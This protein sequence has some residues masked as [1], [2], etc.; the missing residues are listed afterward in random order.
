L[1]LLLWLPISLPIF[2]PL[3]WNNL[4]DFIY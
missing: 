1:D 2:I 4:K 3:G